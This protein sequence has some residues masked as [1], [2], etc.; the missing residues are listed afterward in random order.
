MKEQLKVI[1]TINYINRHS[2][3]EK[4]S[5]KLKSVLIKYKDVQ[6]ISRVKN[7]KSALQKMEIRK[8][9]QANEI[10][11]YIGYMIITNNINEVYRIKKDIENLYIFFYHIIMLILQLLRLL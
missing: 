5:E 3:C 2:L 10:S 9:K 11:D 1:K 8:F 4:Y 7:K 6:L